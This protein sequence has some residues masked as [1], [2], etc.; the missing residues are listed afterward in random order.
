MDLGTL[1]IASIAAISIVLIALGISMSGSGG[2]TLE[3]LERYAA[4]AKPNE[5]AA[6]GQGGMAELIAKSAAL[7][8][9]NRVVEKR[10]FGANLLRDLGAA[11]LKLKPSEYLAIWAGT[12]IGLPIVMYLIGFVVKALQN[13]IVLIIGLIVGFMLPRFWL[14]RRTSSRLNS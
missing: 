14:G 4:G 5:P 11:D 12:T 1:V 2:V 6:S 13:P 9:L 3:R 7:A 8:Q 10:D